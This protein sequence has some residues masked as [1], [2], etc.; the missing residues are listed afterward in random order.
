MVKELA[1][2]QS[3]TLDELLRSKKLVYTPPIKGYSFNDF[4]KLRK[5]VNSLVKT[6]KDEKYKKLNFTIVNNVRFNTNLLQL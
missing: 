6:T 2:N 3:I 5:D 4:N 1:M